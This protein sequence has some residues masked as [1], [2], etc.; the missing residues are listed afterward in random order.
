MHERTSSPPPPPPHPLRFFA[1]NANFGPS[2]RIGEKLID[3][4]VVASGGV[5]L[6][7][8]TAGTAVAPWSFFLSASALCDSTMYSIL[9]P[10]GYVAV[11]N[12]AATANSFTC[13]CQS[14]ASTSFSATKRLGKQLV[15]A[16]VANFTAY[17]APTPSGLI[18]DNY[19]NVCNFVM[20]AS[21]FGCQAPS[22]G[23]SCGG[24]GGALQSFSKGCTCNSPWSLT[25]NT[26]TDRIWEKLLDRAL[27][28]A[29][30]SAQ[31]QYAAGPPGGPA[32]VV[33]PMASF[34]AVCNA[35]MA[36]LSCPAFQNNSAYGPGV[37]LSCTC[38]SFDATGRIVELVMDAVLSG[39]YNA[40][41]LAAMPMAQYAPQ[42][43]A[44]AAAPACDSGV[45]AVVA[46]VIL[47]IIAAILAA[48][49]AMPLFS[50]RDTS[51]M[52][53]GVQVKN[54]AAGP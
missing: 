40:T 32:I 23:T 35:A 24:P 47:G 36:A 41:Q 50:K 38:G 44:A 54:P 2:L 5:A 31:L 53:G 3:A 30:V 9:C 8:Y 7:P 11:S 20:S 37:T 51:R 43:A 21:G 27:P 45:G 49:V 42:P 13:S 15:D 33:D 4:A 46:A 25:D 10:A 16:V 34:G 6:V 52:F 28:A 1:R 12:N 22:V 48:V 17:V 19:V 18:C 39:Y 14:G 26:I 29:N